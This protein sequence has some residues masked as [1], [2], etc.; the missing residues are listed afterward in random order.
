MTDQEF[1][2]RLRLLA[3]E[4]DREGGSYQES[5]YQGFDVFEWV[6][7]RLLNI[8]ATDDVAAWRKELG[9]DAIFR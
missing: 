7:A 2:E 8:P 4:Y 3:L 1:V 9:P 6:R 5:T